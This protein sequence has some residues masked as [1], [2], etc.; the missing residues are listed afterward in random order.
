MKLSNETILFT[1]L[2]IPTTMSNA[3]SCGPG[4][5]RYGV[6]LKGPSSLMMDSFLTLDQIRRRRQEF[7]DRAFTRISPQYSITDTDDEIKISID[8]P[9]VRAQDVQV[10]LDNDGKVLTVTG[11][12]EKQGTKTSGDDSTYSS[13]SS[14]SKFSQSFTMDPTVDVD[15]FRASLQNGVLV[16]T[17]P[18]DLQ[19]IETNIRRIPI[20]TDSFDLDESAGAEVDVVSEV[21]GEAQESKDAEDG[22]VEPASE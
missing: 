6:V 8:V 1:F 11:R 14:S 17:A 12:R 15:K 20:E 18:K 7:F 10:T 9:G 5:S 21:K 13:H 16:I 4:G 22:N 3:W 19:R 2:A